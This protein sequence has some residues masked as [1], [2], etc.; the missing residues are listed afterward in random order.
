MKEKKNNKKPKLPH[1]VG[2]FLNLGSRKSKSI[3]YV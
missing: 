3:Q 1:R 2:F